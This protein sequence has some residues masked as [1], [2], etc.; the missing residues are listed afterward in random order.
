MF[1]QRSFW[2]FYPPR[3][4]PATLSWG[5]DLLCSLVSHPA[6]F[7]TLIGLTWNVIKSIRQ[8]FFLV[9]PLPKSALVFETSLYYK[10]KWYS[11]EFRG[12]G[13]WTLLRRP[14]IKDVTLLTP[15]VTSINTPSVGLQLFLSGDGWSNR[16]QYIDQTESITRTPAQCKVY[17]H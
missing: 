15:N 2:R 6:P 16:W 3:L 4:E 17:V 14:T 7:P 10:W 13:Q 1:G 9:K 12:K 5:P 8:G 11:H